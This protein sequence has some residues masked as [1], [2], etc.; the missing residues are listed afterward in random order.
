VIDAAEQQ[1]EL[2]AALLSLAKGQRGIDRKETFD[3]GPIANEVLRSESHFAERRGLGIDTDLE[4][5]VV[6]GAAPLIEQLIRNL[7]DNAILHNV[8]GGSIHLTTKTEA[9]QGVIAVYNDG[10]IIPTS[11]LERLF[12]PFERLESGRR[13]HKTGH[14]LGLSIVDAIA[15]AHGAVIVAHSRPEGGL[16]FEITFPSPTPAFETPT[17]ATDR[18]RGKRLV[19][20][21]RNSEISHL[22][23]SNTNPT[24]TEL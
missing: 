12:R 22:G 20:A 15:T 21:P 23:R 10:P 9:G 4:P 6:D 8:A 11:E 18:A 3:L 7:V 2:I 1:E 13:H 19:D 16:S 17:N 14:G 24:R 5:A